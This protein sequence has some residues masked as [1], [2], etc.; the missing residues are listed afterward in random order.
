ME[1]IEE[2]EPTRR[3][4]YAG[5]VG[6]LAFPGNMDTC[7][8]IRCILIKAGKPTS[9]WVQGSWPILSREKEFE[10]T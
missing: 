2:L 1:I 10:D 6:Y 3:G 9:R 8:T 5:A 4:P 7:I